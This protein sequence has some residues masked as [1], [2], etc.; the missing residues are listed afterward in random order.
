MPCTCME[1][2]RAFGVCRLEWIGS[3]G[4]RGLRDQNSWEM[5]IRIMRSSS[6]TKEI[7]YHL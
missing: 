7:G 3:D 1:S 4:G 2:E 5:Q 6:H